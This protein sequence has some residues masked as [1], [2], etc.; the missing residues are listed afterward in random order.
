MAALLTSSMRGLEIYLLQQS[1]RE[2]RRRPV[3]AVALGSIWAQRWFGFY[4]SHNASGM[5]PLSRCFII[6]ITAVTLPRWLGCRQNMRKGWRAVDALFVLITE[7]EKTLRVSLCSGLIYDCCLI[8]QK[9]RAERAASGQPSS[10]LHFCPL[11]LQLSLSVTLISSAS[12]SS[13]SPPP[14]RSS[15]FPSCSVCLSVS[16]SQSHVLIAWQA[17][18]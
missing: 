5:S 11:G 14:A 7:R 9:E 17:G 8:S 16:S 2:A 3:R 13:L 1:C 18:Q 10:Y 4:Y 12:V 15:Y 6:I